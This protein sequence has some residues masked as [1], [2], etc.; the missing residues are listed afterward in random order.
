MMLDPKKLQDQ[1]EKQEKIRQQER[2]MAKKL[3]QDAELSCR[4]DVVALYPEEILETDG[5]Q[6]SSDAAEKE[7]LRFAYVIAVG[8]GKPVE[9]KQ[10]QHEG[11]LYEGTQW[12]RSTRD[13]SPGDR[14]AYRHRGV[15][16][17]KI[18]D[19]SLVLVNEPWIFSVIQ[20]EAIK[21]SGHPH[22]NIDGDK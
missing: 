4:N 1:Q 7:D 22:F 3:M 13:L 11:V 18:M 9:S 21:I 5:I 8:P 6:L 10:L 15:T 2:D 16:M 14:V 19:T 20:K 12:V 17:I